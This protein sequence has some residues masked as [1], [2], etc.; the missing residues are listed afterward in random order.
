M[1]AA[2]LVLAAAQSDCITAPQSASCENFTFPGAQSLVAD[3]CAS[4]DNMPGC[5]IL[6][7]CQNTQYNASTNGNGVCTYFSLAVDLC[8][9]MPDME[10]ARCAN[11][12][13]MCHPTTGTSA[14]QQ[15]STP[16][17][18]STMPTY[19]D[20]RANLSSLCTNNP[21]SGAPCSTCTS[22][23]YKCDLLTTYISTCALAPTRAEC[24]GAP[25]FCNSVAAYNWPVC[26]SLAPVAPVVPAAPTA[27]NCAL[28]PSNPACASYH[29]ADPAGTVKD[30]CDMMDT[31]PGCSV[32]TR[33]CGNSKYS[34]SEYCEP[35]SLMADVCTDMTMGVTG[36][37]LYQN[38]CTTGTAV[39]ECSSPSLKAVLPT[40]KVARDN[41]KAICDSMPM[42]D[43]SSCSSGSC[44]YLTV[45]SN[46]CMAMPTMSQCGDW[47]LFCKAVPN[48]PYCSSDA[49]GIPEMRMYFH[50][51]FVDYVLFYGWVPR[52]GVQYAFTWIAI[53]VAG[54]LLELLKFVRARLEKRWLQRGSHYAGVVN[55]SE[56]DFNPNSH[57]SSHHHS[58]SS[59]P[60]EYPPW[61]WRV[62]IPRSI[63]AA[64]ELI[65][66]YA[67]MLV[68]M[69]FNVG[70]FFAVV[71]GAFAGTLIFG[72]FL[73]SLPKPKTVSCH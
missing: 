49:S 31:M 54:I 23:N 7:T 32:R 40:T 38:V 39:T 51:G 62:D 28:T 46:L 53:A 56:E 6:H 12:T 44:D 11:L 22:V 45:Y 15:C 2:L 4:M 64:I 59:T 3:F 16:S 47:S 42:S 65:W 71:F 61:D 21:P 73:V 14:V 24:A 52:T 63:L 50:T 18:I 8:F 60:S 70:L 26:S 33:V 69:T 66:S 67:L 29:F 30:M 43:C 17:L 25:I 55:S 20:L 57:G 68:A 35:L 48:W 19:S 1:V 72:R 27:L 36:C 10:T 41:I 58:S 37:V 34:S 13:K 9:D 5:T